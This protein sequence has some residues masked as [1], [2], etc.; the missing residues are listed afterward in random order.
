MLRPQPGMGDRGSL[1]DKDNENWKVLLRTL[2]TLPFT[3][4]ETGL[5]KGGS[6]DWAS[7]VTLLKVVSSLLYSR[8]NNIV[9][10]WHSPQQGP[11]CHQNIRCSYETRR[12]SSTVARGLFM[13]LT[14]QW[15][16]VKVYTTS[17][18]KQ[19]SPNHTHS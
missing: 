10:F 14:P 3:R 6:D 2:S 18:E 9:S 11:V 1:A 5:G 19:S 16:D 4:E 15:W 8:P 12:K 13:P 7:L 17:K